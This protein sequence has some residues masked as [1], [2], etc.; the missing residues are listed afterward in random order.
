MRAAFSALAMTFVLAFSAMLA[1]SAAEVAIPPA[2][3]AWVTDTATFLNPQIV[4]AL[5]SRLRAYEV[6]TG[7]QVIVYVAPTTGDTPTE[8]W[9]SRAFARWKVGRKGIDDGL[10]L[11]VFPRDRKA[12]I[13]V[14]YGLEQTVP[15]AIA[16]RIVRNTIAP[17]IGAGH[18][19]A[20]VT[21][22]VDQLLAVIGGEAAP[23]TVVTAAPQSV[24][25]PLPD[26]DTDN[27]QSPFSV[28]LG[29]VIALLVVV[30]VG[31]IIGKL[32]PIRDPHITG[33][34]SGFGL[35]DAFAIGGMLLG[36]IGGGG[37][38][39]FS[40]GGGSGGGGG[41]TGSW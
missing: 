10:V 36:G 25:T 13:E 6:T 21:A 20:A 1:V 14:G 2:P 31:W 4:D 41:A 12:R 19:D 16:S 27:G 40:G 30:A 29:V 7:H 39:G 38:G 18:P 5:D 28:F 35:G 37:S 11:F 33:H 15:D 9:T 34:N 3:S 17:Q 26:Y 23:Q 32:P 24:A 8:E 22:G